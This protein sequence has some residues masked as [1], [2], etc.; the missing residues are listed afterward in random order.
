M[1]YKRLIDEN[2]L[3]RNF[4]DSC[5]GDCRRCSLYSVEY[6]A[7]GCGLISLA[8][9]IDAVEVVRCSECKKHIKRNDSEGLVYCD[10]W[11][12]STLPCGFC[13][14]GAKMDANEKEENP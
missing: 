14:M 9:T 5:I 10:F 8:P 7:Y 12:K 13:H 3:D 4:I 2:A 11:R 6:G 1:P